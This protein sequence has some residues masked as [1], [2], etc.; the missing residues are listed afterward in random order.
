MKVYNKLVRDRIPEIIEQTGQNCD[1]IIVQDKA[2]LIRLLEQKLQEE[3]AEY[4]AEQKVEEIADM[5]E[6][7]FA[8]SEKLGTDRESLL[9]LLEAKVSE[10]GGFTKGIFL[11]TV[12]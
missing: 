7:L 12:G 2:D 8:L 9:K 1:Y 10:R 4:E 11:K 5:L 3:L 6:V